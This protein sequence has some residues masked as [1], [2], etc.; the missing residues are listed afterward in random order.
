MR[1]VALTS[2]VLCEL[3]ECA[4]REEGSLPIQCCVRYRFFANYLSR[5]RSRSPPR[6][7]HVHYYIYNIRRPERNLL[8]KFTAIDQHARG[9]S[10]RRRECGTGQR[11]CAAGNER[12]AGCSREGR[13]CRWRTARR[14]GLSV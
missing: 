8:S 12:S 14:V 2:P 9:A 5:S 13:G 4:T 7:S 1:A 6:L 10:P 11:Q 3:P